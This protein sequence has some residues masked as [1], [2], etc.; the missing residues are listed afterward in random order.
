MRKGGTFTPKTAAG[1]PLGNSGGG[2]TVRL[3][4]SGGT[5]VAK[6]QAVGQCRTSLMQETGAPVFIVSVKNGSCHGSI[7]GW[8]LSECLLIDDSD[9]PVEDDVQKVVVD[10]CH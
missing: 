3:L 2:P 4:P 1:Q 9:F 6:V 8:D 5:N 7:C 10:D